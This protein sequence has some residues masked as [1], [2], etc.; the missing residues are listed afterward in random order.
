MQVV[1]FNSEPVRI[2]D[3][4]AMGE[5]F[6]TL[7]TRKD[8]I[9]FGDYIENHPDNLGKDPFP[10]FHRFAGGIYTREMHAP[11]GAIIVG[12]IHKDAYHISVLKGRI[13]VV[14]EFG[15]R[16]I[17]APFSF[18]AREGVKNIGYV[19]ED[20]VWVDSTRTDK[21]TVEEAEKEMFVDDYETLNERLHI[22]EGV[23][24]Q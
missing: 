22:V 2:D 1:T 15:I 23:C 24:Q 11:A 9:R 13:W 20:L 16:E 18:T 7:T 4:T 6:K 8:I 21:T 12:A 3:V 14:N 5:L 19:L 10:I 17:V